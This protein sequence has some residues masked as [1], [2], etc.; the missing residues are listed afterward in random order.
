[1]QSNKA[2]SKIPTATSSAGFTTSNGQNSRLSKTQCKF[3]TQHLLTS[4]KCDTALT[5]AFLGLLKIVISAS[6]PTLKAVAT[7]GKRPNKFWNQPELTKS[8][9]FY[10]M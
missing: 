7:T 3:L 8:S 1:M 6:Y 5:S 4:N 9:S 10:T 2:D